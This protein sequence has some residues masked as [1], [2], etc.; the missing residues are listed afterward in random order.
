MTSAIG[1]RQGLS[2][3][4]AR[5]P[6]VHTAAVVGAQIVGRAR[7]RRQVDRYL[8]ESVRP[9]CLRFGSGRHVDAGWLSADIVPAAW[10]VVYM[11]ATRPLPLPSHSFDAILCEHMIEHIALPDGFDLLAEFHRVLRPHGVL[12][13]STPNLDTVRALPDQ[14][15]QADVAE[16]ITW[17]NQTFG[18]PIEQADLG[19]SAYVVNR[20]MREWGHTFIYDEVTLRAALEQA[21]FRGIERVEPG[22]SRHVHLEGV[23]RHA[24][25]IGETAD[26]FETLA[27]EAIA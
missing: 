26:R 15:Q 4:V 18:G 25:L 2:G 21:G 27:L 12:R 11:D 23:D 8:E 5:H 16:Y 10:D 6:A 20:L 3:I 7:Q 22:H 14:A 19:N 1:G 9:R 13:I 24:E 17:S